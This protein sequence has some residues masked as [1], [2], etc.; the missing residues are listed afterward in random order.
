MNSFYYWMLFAISF[1]AQWIHIAGRAEASASSK[2]SGIES[3][4]HFIGFNR[5]EIYGRLCWQNGLMLWW[6]NDPDLLTNLV[7]VVAHN[8]SIPLNIGTAILYGYA[9][10]SFFDL[11]VAVFMRRLRKEL[12]PA[13]TGG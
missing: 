13:S 1:C 7:G 10:D 5:W 9:A 3:I 11:F 8:F 4:R 6:M 12:K 2:L